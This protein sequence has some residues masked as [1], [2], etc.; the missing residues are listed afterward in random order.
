MYKASTFAESG[1][2]TW[3]LCQ[4]FN[5]EQRCHVRCHDSANV[6][7]I[8]ST[9]SFI[10]NTQ[11]LTACSLGVRL[12]S[13]Q[14]AVQ[15]SLGLKWP[16]RCT[17]Y[18]H[19]WNVCCGSASCSLCRVTLI[20]LARLGPLVSDPNSINL[21]IISAENYIDVCVSFRSLWHQIVFL[22]KCSWFS[23]KAGFARRDESQSPCRR[24]QLEFIM[25][26]GQRSDETM[27]DI[28]IFQSH[29]L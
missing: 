14:R 3:H 15:R 26:E 8:F 20:C 23:V 9:I 24:R 12:I 22:F 29:M 4:Y 27:L 10:I 11:K 1:R 7:A 13:G 5:S 25:F 6:L 19:I 28:F 16:Q 17:F 2:I 18:A 21:L